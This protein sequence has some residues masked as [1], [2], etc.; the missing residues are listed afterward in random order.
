MNIFP[1][2]FIFLPLSSSSSILSD[3]LDNTTINTPIAVIQAI[4]PNIEEAILS[5]SIFDIVF[6]AFA[7]I[8]IPTDIP[9]IDANIF[10]I[11]GNFAFANLSDNAAIKPI[12]AASAKPITPNAIAPCCNSSF[13]NFARTN[14]AAAKIPIDIAILLIIAATA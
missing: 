3:T 2:C 4:R 8:N 9:N 14:K 6:K 1:S 13:G 12:N 5:G 11:S 10:P 7:I